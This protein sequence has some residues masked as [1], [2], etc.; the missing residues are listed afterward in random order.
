MQC[1][2]FVFINNAIYEAIIPLFAIREAL[3]P[4]LK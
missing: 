2:Q 1:K 4:L 3:I